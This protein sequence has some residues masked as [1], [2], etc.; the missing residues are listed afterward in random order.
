MSFADVMLSGYQCHL[1]SGSH[2]HTAA[3]VCAHLLAMA[4]LLYDAF[5]FTGP[6]LVTIQ[7]IQN[8]DLAIPVDKIW[9][10]AYFRI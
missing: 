2:K 9:I 7:R 1:L 10:V 8:S 5:M 6:V 4:G 3:G